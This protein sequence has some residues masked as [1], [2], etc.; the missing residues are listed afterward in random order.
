LLDFDSRAAIGA[1]SAPRLLELAQKQSR[2]KGIITGRTLGNVFT[3]MRPDDLVFNYWVNNYLMGEN[4]PVFDILA[5]NADS[6]N[7][8]ARLHTEF[9][10]I[11]KNNTLCQPGG[12]E[13]LGTPVDL[14]RIT[15]PT[16]VT[17]AT[18]DHLT[19][20]KGCY[21]TTELVGGQSTFILSNAGHIAALV[22]PPGNPK[23]SYYADGDLGTDPDT[24]LK[25]ATKRPGSWWE[26]WADWAIGHAADSVPAPSS[27]GSTVH[28]PL[29]PAPG[30][31][32]RDK[33]PA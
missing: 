27:P 30:A 8:P 2:R 29:A 13:I 16:F 25:S 12:T 6:T 14:S 22:N 10:E 32:V 7:L 15:V 18:T 23:A 31:Y 4:P 20:W 33:T 11:F 17:G 24:W 1:F 28:P 21:R 26:V 19:P 9:L 5:W 3:W